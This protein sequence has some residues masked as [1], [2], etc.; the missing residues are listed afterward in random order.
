MS[1]ARRASGRA[2]LVLAG[3]LLALTVGEISIRVARLDQYR[4]PAILD[5]SGRHLADLSG[6]ERFVA[7]TAAERG[8]SLTTV[9]P[10]L[11]VRGWY[12]RPKWDYFD[13]DGCI[14]YRTNSL[15]FR[16]REFPLDRPPGELRVLCVGDSFTFGL[17]VEG[18][19]A[20]PQQLEARLLRRLGGQIEVINGGY[21]SGVHPPTYAPW[22]ARHPARLDVD[23]L[24]LGICLNDLDADIPMYM[25]LRPRVRPLLGGHVRL[26]AVAGQALDGWLDQRATVPPPVR[27]RRYLDRHAEKWGAF[28]TALISIRDSCN[29]AG[30][31]LLVVVFPMLSQLS[32][33]YP[34]GEFHQAISDFCG[35]SGIE[36]LDTLPPF[37]GRDEQALWVHPTDQHMNDVGHALLADALMEWFA[38]RPL[39]PRPR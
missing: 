16:D 2:V 4:P 1:R 12:D 3:A 6:I 11:D 17:G 20:W 28:R 24:L 25:P 21:A 36:C 8:T 30:I 10:N 7:G 31:R 22:I 29:V 32:R 14:T 27:A 39:A 23:A 38:A 13:A 19:D 34:Y 18:E 15:G 35:Q 9:V 33:G 5:P 26:L 37:L